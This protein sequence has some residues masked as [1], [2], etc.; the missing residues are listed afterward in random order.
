MKN[1]ISLKEVFAEDMKNPWF[2]FLYTIGKPKR[3]LIVSWCCFKGWFKMKVLG[4][5][6]DWESQDWIK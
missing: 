4:W 1:T 5:E 3:W 2:R 6:Y